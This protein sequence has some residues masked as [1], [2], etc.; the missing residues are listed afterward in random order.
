MLQRPSVVVVLLLLLLLLLASLAD[1]APGRG[2]REDTYAAPHEEVASH[3]EE[4]RAL[5]ADGDGRLAHAEIVAGAAGET[6]EIESG[7]VLAFIEELDTDGDGQVGWEEY[8]HALLHQEFENQIPEEFGGDMDE[9]VQSANALS[10]HAQKL[11][12]QRHAAP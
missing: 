10:E 9:F 2:G 11:H 8:T 1:A 5:D 6:H 3:R 7:D 12:R 4:F